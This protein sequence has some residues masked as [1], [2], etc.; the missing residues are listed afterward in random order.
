MR[1]YYRTLVLACMAFG[2][3]TLSSCGEDGGKHRS[4]NGE[5]PEAWP[6]LVSR[7][8]SFATLTTAESEPQAL[9]TFWK[10]TG[11]QLHQAGLLELIIDHGFIYDEFD[12]LNV[13]GEMTEKARKF[14]QLRDRLEKA[15]LQKVGL[16]ETDLPSARAEGGCFYSAWEEYLTR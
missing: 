5:M 1:P 9:W 8:G 7:M 16:P 13:S 11:K 6:E 15:I 2:L 14:S 10:E 3:V 12:S 4:R